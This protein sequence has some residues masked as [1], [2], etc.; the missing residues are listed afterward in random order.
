M[1]SYTVVDFDSTYIDGVAST[2]AS[3]DGNTHYIG[4]YRL[5]TSPTEVQQMIQAI[6]TN[7]AGLR[8]A[9]ARYVKCHIV[10]TT[11]FS[12]QFNVTGNDGATLTYPTGQWYPYQICIIEYS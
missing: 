9:G 5:L 4:G 1:P 7:M 3:I 12:Q 10:D 8:S 6:V 2:D 11:T